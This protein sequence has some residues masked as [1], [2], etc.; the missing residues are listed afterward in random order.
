[1]NKIAK[2]SIW[3]LI[4]SL[5]LCFAVSSMSLA[6]TAGW[7]PSINTEGISP[8]PPTGNGMESITEGIGKV[9][10]AAQWIGLIVGIGMIIYIGVKYLTAGAGKKA[11]GQAGLSAEQ[12]PQ[13]A[14][15]GRAAG[16][17]Q[18]R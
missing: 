7:T 17:G 12:R 14:P 13:A 4:L 1:M 6:A 16:Q 10:G 11:P 9:L 3:M 18:S 15:A 2:K 5:A 8:T